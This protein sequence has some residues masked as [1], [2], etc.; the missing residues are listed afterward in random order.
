MIPKMPEEY[1]GKTNKNGGYTTTAPR[2]WRNIGR[3][4]FAIEPIK[5][6]EQWE[7]KKEGAK[8]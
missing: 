7:C 2:E 4:W 6:V 8:Q 1:K 5:I 3:V